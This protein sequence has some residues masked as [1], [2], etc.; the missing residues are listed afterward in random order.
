MSAII[1]F[2]TPLMFQVL[3]D[4]VITHRSYQTLFAMVLMF[5][6]LTLF[7]GL[8]SYVRQYLMTVITSKIDARLASRIFQR[9]M[10]LPMHFFENTS[11]GVLARNLQ[12]TDTIRQFLTG[13]LFQ[14]MLD[15]LSLPIMLV[16]L[17]LYSA[18]L[19]AVVL[20]FSCAMAVIIGVMLP[21]FR[22]HLDGLYA[23]EGARQGH[24]VE[25]LHGMRTVKS[26]SLEPARI[27]EWNERVTT[28]V[29]RRAAVGRIAALAG[30]A[31]IWPGKSH[32]NQR[33]WPGCGGS[34]Q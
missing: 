9:L 24:L 1:A 25:T 10:T 30:R 33:A 29:Q 4:K 28:G 2:A 15:A 3:I 6:T 23:A 27:A 34:V 31:D 13:R 14:T 19:T 7:D 16:V 26:L 8:F 11:A 22:R 32:A 18:T 5:G 12:Q 20:G 17:L 21:T